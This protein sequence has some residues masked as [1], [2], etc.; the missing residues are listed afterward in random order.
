MA[1]ECLTVLENGML[2][3]QY[4]LSDDREVAFAFHTLSEVGEPFQAWFRSEIETRGLQVAFGRDLDDKPYVADF[5]TG[6]SQDAIEAALKEALFKLGW[7]PARGS[8]LAIKGYPTAVG[9][10][11]AVVY[12]QLAAADHAYML[13]GDYFSEGRN[14][15]ESE[16]MMIPRNT[17]PHALTDL[18]SVFASRTDHVI[19]ESYA[20]RLLRY[21]TARKG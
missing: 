3:Y 4:A 14:I 20:A 15:L 21:S 17:L 13:Q 9:I 16:F 5:V 12:L 10:K 11:Q 18:A 1:H 2:R 8:A 7:A 6:L 19:S